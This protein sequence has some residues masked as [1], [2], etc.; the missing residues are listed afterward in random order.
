VYPF[1]VQVELCHSRNIQVPTNCAVLSAVAVI[2]PEVLDEA[3]RTLAAGKSY[4]IYKAML[5]E[6]KLGRLGLAV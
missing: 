3:A 2:P 4:G 1:L 6:G 5:T